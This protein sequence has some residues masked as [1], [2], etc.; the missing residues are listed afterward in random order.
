[1][2]S[3]P[4]RDMKKDAKLVNPVKQI[5]CLNCSQAAPKP[6]WITKGIV[7]CILREPLSKESILSL[8]ITAPALCGGHSQEQILDAQTADKLGPSLPISPPWSGKGWAGC[9]GPEDVSWQQGVGQCL[10]Q[11]F[12]VHRPW[13]HLLSTHVQVRKTTNERD[14]HPCHHVLVCK[15]S[16]GL[17]SITGLFPVCLCAETSISWAV[18]KNLLQ[19][20]DNFGLW[21]LWRDIVACITRLPG[22][23]MMAMIAVH[24]TLLFDCNYNSMGDVVPD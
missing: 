22:C 19:I 4:G 3:W 16:F 17:K 1:M 5:L 2:L 10:W 12:A 14:L 7:K 24:I 21:R 9:S 18:F 13:D 23:L 20:V 6:E 8:Q 15:I 11:R